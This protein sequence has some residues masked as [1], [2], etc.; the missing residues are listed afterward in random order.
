MALS[1]S[2]LKGSLK[3]DIILLN[4]AMKA[5]PLSDAD[6]A[7]Q[8]AGLIAKRV[9]DELKDNAVIPSGIAVS[10]SPA[11]GIGETTGTGTIT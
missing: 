6:Y 3:A 7:D 4:T 11:T 10:V 2:R 1:E 8:L 9:L 5:A